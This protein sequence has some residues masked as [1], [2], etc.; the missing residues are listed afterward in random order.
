[1]D[2]SVLKIMRGLKLIEISNSD[3][4]WEVFC[5]GYE[6]EAGFVPDRLDGDTICAVYT[7]NEMVGAAS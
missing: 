1:M 3:P 7:G 2:S 5:R 6:S 4:E